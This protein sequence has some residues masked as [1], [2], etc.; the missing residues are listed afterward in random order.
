MREVEAK[1]EGGWRLKKREGGSE[2][3][4]RKDLQ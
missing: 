1:K 3:R 2:K 4:E